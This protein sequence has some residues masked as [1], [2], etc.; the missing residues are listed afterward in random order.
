MRKAGVYCEP[1]FGLPLWVGRRPLVDTPVE[2]LTDGRLAA[3]QALFRIGVR[4]DPHLRPLGLDERPLR[5][6]VFCAGAVLGGTDPDLDGSGLGVAILS[7]YL[8][9]T[10]AG[11]H[12]C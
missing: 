1:V 9:G 5:E 2:V 10:E 11:S 6:D 8:A 12:R 7:G 3:P 4:T